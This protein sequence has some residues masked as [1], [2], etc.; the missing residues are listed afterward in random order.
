MDLIKYHHI[1]NPNSKL[2]ERIGYNIP[3]DEKWVATEK[4][5]GA[6]L[7]VHIFPN[8]TH[9]FASR[10]QWLEEDTK[11][12]GYETIKDDILKRCLSIY[13]NV[14]FTERLI[15]YG[16]I[17]GGCYPE[18]K[19]PNN[20]SRLQNDIYYAHLLHFRAFDIKLDGSWLNYFEFEN[21]CKIGDLPYCQP[22]F[23][24]TLDECLEFDVENFLTPIPE[25]LGYK[26]VN[27]NYA[28]GIVVKPVKN[29]LLLN[30]SRII[31]KI[32]KQ[33]FSDKQQRIKISK[34]N[35]ITIGDDIIK[36]T[37]DISQYVNINTLNSVKSKLNEKDLKNQQKIAG[38]VVSDAISTYKRD[39][40]NIVMPDDKKEKKYISN[41]LSKMVSQLK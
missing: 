26:Q 38:L 36:L 5:H 37:E 7:S 35:K 17:F 2:L 4:I 16:E 34:T 25:S 15:I 24:G 29:H 19:T 11:F 6:N 1:D 13:K 31:L 21:L 8:G 3:D 33:N 41:T 32:K 39:N 22:L 40:P 28:E 27:N 20:I 9:R 14:D 12:I 10:N 30:G 18:H 23:Y